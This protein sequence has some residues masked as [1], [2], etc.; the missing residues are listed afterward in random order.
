M[1]R[2]ITALIAPG[3]CHLGLGV[4]WGEEG[5]GHKAICLYLSA[6]RFL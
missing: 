2:D 4:G 3:H 5:A 6:L 1:Q